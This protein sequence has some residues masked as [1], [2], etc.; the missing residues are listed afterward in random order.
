MIIECKKFAKKWKKECQGTHA[1]LAIVQVGDNPASNA[2]IKGKI[3]DCEEVGFSFSLHKWPEDVSEEDLIGYINQL[4]NDKSVNGIIVQLPLPAHLDTNKIVNTVAI[5]KDVDGFRPG[6]PYV[7][8]TP[9]GIVRLLDEMEINV[10][11]KMVVILGRSQYLGKKAFELLLNK[12][13]TLA[14]CHSKTPMELRDELL[15]KADIIISA[16]GK[17]GLFTVDHVKENAIVI[18]VGINRTTDGKLVGD[19]VPSDKKEITYTPVPGG[20][21]LITRA[22]LLQNTLSAY[23]AQNTNED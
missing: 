4:N 6:S 14:V 2:Y 16:V 15:A 13:A 21:G 7:P 10:E 5:E 22:M 17:A 1:R 11:G 9:L 12:N 3:K 8:C 19:F 23:Q 18:D 20:V